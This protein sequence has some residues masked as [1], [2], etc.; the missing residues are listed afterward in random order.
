MYTLLDVV[1]PPEEWESQAQENH[2]QEDTIGTASSQIDT[3]MQCQDNDSYIA[4]AIGGV[5]VLILCGFFIYKY[6]KS[7]TKTTN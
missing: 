2:Q 5:I 4:F 1:F 6:R 3:T 7:I